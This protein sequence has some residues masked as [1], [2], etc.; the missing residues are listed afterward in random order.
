[1]R[2]RNKMILSFFIVISLASVIMGFSYYR[3]MSDELQAS[4]L[5]GL[6]RLIEQTA[7]TLDLH[8][9]TVSMIGLGYFSD[10]SLQKFLDT[11]PTF[12]DQ[13]YYNNK[14]EGQRIQNP[15]ISSVTIARLNGEQ[16]SSVYYQ[17]PELR[18]LMKQEL[19]RVGELAHKLEGTPLW[20]VSLTTTR[21]SL[22]PVS[23]ISYVQQLRRI[24]ASAQHPVG[25]LKIDVNPAV[26][27]N[28]LKG[29]HDEE[30]STYYITDKA[31]S[32][33]F[34][35]NS[36][37]IGSSI[38]DQPLFHEYLQ[39]L[40]RHPNHFSFA[41]NNEQYIGFYRQ[42]ANADW[43]IF[44]RAPLQR[45]SDKVNSYGQTVLLI[46]LL[47]FFIAML[48]GSAIAASVTRPLKLLNKKMKQVEMGD[49]HAV[50]QVKGKDEFS[51]IQYSFNK[52]TTEIRALITKVY[53]TELLK[54]EAELKALQ[55]Q[56]NPHFLYNTLGTIDSMAS[57]N[58]EP[59]IGYICRALGG[60]LRYNLNG[61]STATIQ[62]EVTHLEQYLSIY[63]LRFASQFQY[64]IEV[65]ERL[66]QLTV[67]KFLLQPLVENAIIHGL[68][69]KIGPKELSLAI[70]S[71]DNG[72]QLKFDI[73]DNGAGMEAEIR[74]QLQ[75]RLAGGS[76]YAERAG[77]RPMIG[78][79]NVFKR[80]E[81]YAG[82]KPQVTIMSEPRCGTCIQ[83]TIPKLITGGDRHEADDH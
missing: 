33:I 22:S 63:R 83:F 37:L 65:E 31:G 68:E 34:A 4:T 47:S 60:M 49:F 53:E 79:M 76:D 20:A 74:D 2:F 25:L 55:S 17:K 6:N 38:A 52:M 19:Q 16:F 43:L 77:A 26:L 82:C 9:K 13:Q 7:D 12:E 24:T 45:I 58:G 70:C 18:A 10:I 36:E 73:T 46:A 56:I 14:L 1:M 78:L 80:I 42:L 11:P 21:S 44:G 8:L 48:I 35:E 5:Q 81:I 57:I 66:K 27:T 51:T 69:Q 62:E 15:L 67:P 30:G 40:G 29:L 75:Q 32:I 28:A 72:R 59:R 64:T 54:K 71:H 23:T 61:G 39:S 41:E 50:I 3:M